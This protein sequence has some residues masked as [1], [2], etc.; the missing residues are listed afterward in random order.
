[1]YRYGLYLDDTGRTEAGLELWKSAA[2]RAN[3]VPELGSTQASMLAQG[4]L[5]RALMESCTVALELAEEVKALP[6]GPVA[7]F[8][9]GMAAALCGDEPY[10]ERTIIAM[11]QR[12][13]R[14]TA[15]E[16]YYIPQLQA[17]A[18]I[19]VNEPEKAID[20]LIDLE[21][22]DQ[23]SLTPYLRGMAD[24]AL[25]QMPAAILDFETMAGHR[26]AALTL[27]S[28]A[29]PM[30]VVGVA[31]ARATKRDKKESAEAY[32]RFLMLWGEADQGQPL[33]KEALARSK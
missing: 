31:R 20:S 22:Y 26:G 8:N 12:Y 2:A 27:G 19:G 4:A 15:V 9:A 11:Q 16:Q 23:I 29:Y 14:S 21:Q 3:G 10:A 25:G 32:Q 24:A 18:Q 17:A 30:S 1:V 33:I 28:N 13:P 7:S 5:D 6:K